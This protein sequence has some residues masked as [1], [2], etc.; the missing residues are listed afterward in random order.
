MMETNPAQHLTLTDEPSAAGELRAA[1][2]RIAA[3][4]G[5]PDGT[6]FDLK[7]AAT[8]ALANALKRT[9][10]EGRPVDVRVQHDGEAIEVEVHDRGSFRLD[11]GTG[12]DSERGR[13]IPLMVALVDEVEFAAS[14]DG[15]RVRIRKRLRD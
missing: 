11:H 10:S 12:S 6:R 9:S 15:T 14:R 2:D 3:A 1:V 4:R 5:V 13:G 7:V 8:E